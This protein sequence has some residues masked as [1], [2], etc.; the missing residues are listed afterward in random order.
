MTEECSGWV[1][2]TIERQVMTAILV[3]Q[4]KPEIPDS[5]HPRLR[6]L[7]DRMLT[8]EQAARPSMTEVRCS[9]MCVSRVN[10]PV[11]FLPLLLLLLLFC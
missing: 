2:T 5:F 9:L 8:W 6:K 10:V 4:R 11:S 7:L 1:R 3:K